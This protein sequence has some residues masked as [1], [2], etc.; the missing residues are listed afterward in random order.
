MAGNNAFW[1]TAV[2]SVRPNEIRVR[3]YDLIELHGHGV[4]PDYIR[5]LRELGFAALTVDQVTLLKRDNIVSANAQTEGRT[6][7]AFG[8]APTSVEAVLPSYVVR[9]RPQGQ[10]SRSGGAA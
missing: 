1:R 3:G 6:L 5:E 10:Y 2:S 7:E 8:I 9:Y 4:S